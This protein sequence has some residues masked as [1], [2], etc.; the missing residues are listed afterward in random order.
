MY[1]NKKFPI[2]GLLTYSWQSMLLFAGWSTI[3]VILFKIIGWKF[4]AIPF[5][6]ISLIGTALSF[7]LGFK[8]NASYDRLWEARKNW[9]GIVNASRKWV[10][11]L[12]VYLT[13]YENKNLTEDEIQSIKTRLTKRHIAWLYAHKHYLRNKRQPWEHTK[14]LNDSFRRHYQV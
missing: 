6:P 12:N 7:Y 9:G 13:D 5:L 8:N 11:M 4:I 14:E 2:K 1:V 3:I 10:N